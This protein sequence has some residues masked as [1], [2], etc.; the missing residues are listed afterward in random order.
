MIIIVKRDNPKI[1]AIKSLSFLSIFVMFFLYYQHMSEKFQEQNEKLKGS[2]HIVKKKKVDNKAKQY[3]QT[4]YKEAVKVV[5]LIGQ[6]YIDSIKIYKNRLYIVCSQNADIE[7]I[8]IRYGVYAFIK[9]TKKN[10]KIA[11]DLN[12]ILEKKD[13]V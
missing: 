7:P 10:I 2:L 5:S 6:K 4:I 12:T 13:E 11:I 9:N 8:M 1:L 3:E